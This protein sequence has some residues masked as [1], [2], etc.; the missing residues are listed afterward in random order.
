MKIHLA[1]A[2]LLPLAATPAAAATI[3]GGS[4]LLSSSYAATLESWLTGDPTLSYSGSLVF[5]NI[6]DKAS[7]DT[8]ADFHAAVDGKGATI[9]VMEATDSRNPDQTVLIGGFNPQSWSSS[10]G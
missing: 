5:T 6:F 4:D 2:A 8:S 9:V 1:L 10:G 3:A 7:G